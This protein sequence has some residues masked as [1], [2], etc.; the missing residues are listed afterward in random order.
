MTIIPL[1]GAIVAAVG[2]LWLVKELAA[3]LNASSKKEGA[4]EEFTRLRRAYFRNRAA[5][6]YE[7]L[8]GFPPD[9]PRAAENGV[10]ELARAALGRRRE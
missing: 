10:A 4:A 5:L 2:L 6:E 9:D 7:L 3:G 8:M 1:L